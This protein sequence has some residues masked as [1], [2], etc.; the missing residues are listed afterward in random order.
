MK[1]SLTFF[2]LALTIG[3]FN[4]PAG[5]W[6]AESS[7]TP[8]MS[9][10]KR[11]EGPNMGKMIAETEYGKAYGTKEAQWRNPWEREHSSAHRWARR[12]YSR[13][14]FHKCV[15]SEITGDFHLWIACL[16]AEREDLDLSLDQSERLDKALTVYFKDLIKAEAASLSGMVQLKYDLRQPKVD[17]PS[18]QTQLKDVSDQ[19][20][21]IQL[22]A[23]KTYLSILDILTPAQRQ[24]IDEHIGNAFPSMWHPMEQWG[25]REE[26]HE[27]ESEEHQKD[28]D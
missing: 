13:R 20:Y 26:E 22:S 15:L 18:V 5:A 7:P 21:S 17:M 19:E 10:E 25:A 14:Y 28:K 8:G 11:S 6:A 12:W 4:L 3:V 2:L 27:S 1:R 23:I 9:Q 24:K 16:M